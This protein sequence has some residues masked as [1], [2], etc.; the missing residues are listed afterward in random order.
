MLRINGT[1][2][3]NN[4]FKTVIHSICCITAYPV[5]C[6][7]E[8]SGFSVGIEI[9]INGFG[10]KLSGIHAAQFFKLFVVDNRIVKFD[11]MCK[12]FVFFKEISVSSDNR[13]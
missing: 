6:F 2:G 12:A 4:D 5:N 11:G 8:A 7:F 13:R 3:K 9:S 10:L 1:V